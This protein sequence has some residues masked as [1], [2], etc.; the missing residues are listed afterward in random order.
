MLYSRRFY[1]KAFTVRLIFQKMLDNPVDKR[2]H[3]FTTAKRYEEFC[4]KSSHS[5]FCSIQI[6]DIKLHVYYSNTRIFPEVLHTQHFQK[7]SSRVAMQHAGDIISIQ[8]DTWD[9]YYT[10]WRVL[11]LIT[12]IILVVYHFSSEVHKVLPIVNIKAQSNQNIYNQ[13]TS[14]AI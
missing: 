10:A 9:F 11:L 14:T 2:L 4:L 8:L 5:S 13:A 12:I 6:S 1:S 7:I 3:A